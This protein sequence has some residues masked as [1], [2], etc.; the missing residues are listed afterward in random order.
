MENTTLLLLLDFQDIH[1]NLVFE[2][3]LHLPVFHGSSHDIA[4]NSAWRNA[5]TAS[6]EMQDLR[7]EGMQ[8]IPVRS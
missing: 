5:S 7:F 3:R 1:L 2:L 6:S 8:Q 4:E